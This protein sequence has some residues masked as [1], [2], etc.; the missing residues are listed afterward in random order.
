VVT[1]PIKGL[2]VISELAEK[3]T[4]VGMFKRAMGG[5]TEKDAIQA[6]AFAM[7]SS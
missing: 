2:R 7:S 5:E 4:R 3:A 6:V 1:S